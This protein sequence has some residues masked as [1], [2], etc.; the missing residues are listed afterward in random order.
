[1]RGFLLGISNQQPTSSTRWLSKATQPVQKQG[2]GGSR[3]CNKKYLGNLKY[4]EYKGPTCWME[5]QTQEIKMTR[6]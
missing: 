4:H 1:M 5:T 2:P 3:N 6:R